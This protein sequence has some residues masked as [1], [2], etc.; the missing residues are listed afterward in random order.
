[1]EQHLSHHSGNVFDKESILQ[2]HMGTH[3]H[4]ENDTL[5]KPFNSN[6]L[7]ANSGATNNS[8]S[9]T[10]ASSSMIDERQIDG[11]LKKISEEPTMAETSGYDSESETFIEVATYAGVDVYECYTKDKPPCLIMRRCNDNWLNITQVFKAGSFTK[12]QRTKILEKEAN[13]IKHEKIQGGYGRFQGTWIPWESTKYLVEKY[14]INNKVVKRIVEFIPDPNDMPPRRSKVSQIKKLDPN[15]RITSPSAY[16]KTP[17][18]NAKTPMK[19]KSIRRSGKKDKPVQPSPLHNVMFQT[20]QQ[21]HHHQSQNSNQSTEK[22]PNLASEQ[23]TPMVPVSKVNPDMISQANHPIKYQ[24]TQK[25]LQF[26]PYPQTHQ[27]QQMVPVTNNVAPVPVN[28]NMKSQHNMKILKQMTQ[29]NAGSNNMGHSSGS[30]ISNVTSTGS[31][32][33]V[34]SSNDKASSSSSESPTPLSSAHDKNG[35]STEYYKELILEVL[36]SEYDSVEPTLP[37]ALYRPPSNLDI[38]FLID[39]Q[40]HTSLHWAVAMSNIPLI[41][42]LL[43][44]D[45]DLLRCNDKGFNCLTKSVFYNNCYKAVSFQQ[46]ISM[47]NPCLVTPDANHRLP[48]HYLVELT[49]NRSKEPHVIEYYMDTILDTLAKED[50]KLLRMSLNHQ[51]TLGNT[52]LH[53]AALNKN[54]DLCQKLVY[55]GASPDILNGENQTVSM[56]LSRFT[57]PNIFQPTLPA[58]IL[59]SPPKTTFLANTPRNSQEERIDDTSKYDFNDTTVDSIQTSTRKNNIVDRNDVLSIDKMKGSLTPAIKLHPPSPPTL[60]KPVNRLRRPDAQRVRKE[61][62]SS[63]PTIKSTAQLGSLTQSLSNIIEDNL[64]N[65]QYSI[66]LKEEQI[67]EIENQLK[68]T[69]AREKA[70][71]DSNNR[72]TLGSAQNQ[73]KMKNIELDNYMERSQALSLAT[74]V[75]D[76]ENCLSKD[77]S[78]EA[79]NEFEKKESIKLMVELCYKQFKRRQMIRNI[80]YARDQLV[81]DSKISKF[82]KLIGMSIDNIDSKLNDIEMDLSSMEKTQS[83]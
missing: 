57:V 81:S 63:S 72:N 61:Q 52:P 7:G 3:H 11:S 10:G 78:T 80:K 31:S 46:I 60:V 68:H 59:Q 33:E 17:K 35:V 40:G 5:L 74:L 16:K 38:N 48:L 2:M 30:M 76:E 15:A 42:V 53:L 4:S 51:D 41:R 20:P 44:Q 55:F 79:T 67:Q 1:M 64:D 69:N 27:F 12:A 8:S 14:N 77:S 82:R 24:T 37:E 9:S 62:K 83:R 25:P 39:D 34:F 23:D 71:S 36:S 49:V 19:K 26:Y 29:G 45:A 66:Q 73:L 50:E 47:L 22:L 75:Q 43:V 54:V 58:Q 70:L 18:K 56:I 32:M 21:Q 28:S 6:L 13:E 65:L